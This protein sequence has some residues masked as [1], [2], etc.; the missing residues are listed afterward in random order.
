MTGL[1]PGGLWEPDGLQR[2]FAFA[3]FSGEVEL[4]VGMADGRRLGVVERV[5][6]ALVAALEHI[7]GRPITGDRVLDLCVDDRRYLMQ[8][9]AAEIGITTVWVTVTCPDCAGPF[10]CA[11]HPARLP[12]KAAGPSYPFASVTT[13]VGELRL[14]VPTGRDQQALG[15]PGSQSPTR[16]LIGRCIVE[17]PSQR[18]SG[19]ELAAAMSDDDL[20]R[21]AAALEEASPEVARLATGECPAC[22]GRIEVEVDP[23]LC[24]YLGADRLLDEV[25]ALAAAYHWSEQDILSL[26]RERRRRYLRSTR[27]MAYAG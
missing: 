11:V 6:G 10:D 18:R 22:G 2:E 8:Q 19:A 16:A 9:L 15:S 7:G 12:V 4:I 23:Y 25:E 3:P 5:T 27:R 13:T 1:L 20:E 21:I 24:L 17:A 14:R 26:P